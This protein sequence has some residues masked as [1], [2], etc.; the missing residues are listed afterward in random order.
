MFRY[1]SVGLIVVFLCSALTGCATTGGPF[2]AYS[3]PELR[4]ENIAVISLEPRGNL[5]SIE[6]IDGEAIE[7]GYH[8]AHILAGTHS[9]L[10]VA[11]TDSGI[12]GV[13]L[14]PSQRRSISFTAIEGHV[15]TLHV[16]RTGLGSDSLRLRLVD[17][18]T[19][20]VIAT[21]E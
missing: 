20:A 5:L 10:V 1:R 14:T 16:E 2:R 9:V 12:L 4:Q 11:H 3:G 17:E 21:V 7:E 19:G 6:Y 15:Y 18:G 13:H 8:D